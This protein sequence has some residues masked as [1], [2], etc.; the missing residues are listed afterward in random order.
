MKR[1]L[2]LVWFLG[3]AWSASAAEIKQATQGDCS[4]ALAYVG[5]NVEIKCGI[6]KKELHQL[7]IE[8]SDLQKQEKLSGT[9]MEKLLAA[10]NAMLGVVVAK[11]DQVATKQD[12]E[13]MTQLIQTELRGG[14]DG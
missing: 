9:R 13:K 11:L 4:A 12:L 6:H 5:G 10:I 1:T 2:F 3:W 7:A 8:L 14:Q